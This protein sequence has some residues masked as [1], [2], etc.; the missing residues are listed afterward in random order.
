MDW[1]NKGGFT[2]LLHHPGFLKSENYGSAREWPPA[3]PPPAAAPTRRLHRR[4]LHLAP[5]HRPT[6]VLAPRAAGHGHG[7]EEEHE[8]AGS[9]GRGDRTGVWNGPAPR[10]YVAEPMHVSWGGGAAAD[11][12]GTRQPVRR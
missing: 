7:E 9:S 1:A 10:G 3:T 8:E 4:R 6:C 12:P 5:A 11:L 2:H